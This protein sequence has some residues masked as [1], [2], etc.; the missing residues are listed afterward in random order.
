MRRIGF[1]LL[2][3][4]FVTLGLGSAMGQDD[5]TTYLFAEYYSCDQNREAF[6]DI[7][8]E[9]ILGPVYQKHVDEGNLQGWGWLGHRAGGEWRRVLFYSAND[10]KKLMETRD[11]IVGEFQNEL[12]AEGHEFTSI[13]PDHDD[14]IWASVAGPPIASQ[15]ENMGAK[16]YS[17]YYICDVSRQERADEIVK[18]LLAPAINELM[19][20]GELNSWGWYEHVIG[21]RFRRLMTHS[22]MD[23]VT[24]MEAVDKYNQAAGE[25]NEAMSNEFS[26]ICNGHV[27][28]LWDRVL[29]KPAEGND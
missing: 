1:G 12:A 28:Y 25:A 5:Q 18:E 22:G 3:C 29:P 19:E 11:E 24:L 13:C 9:H 16:T 15:L 7:L 21:G 17:T 23:H 2:L 8:V 4:V 10:L 14:L 6:A 26:E 27:D 20:A